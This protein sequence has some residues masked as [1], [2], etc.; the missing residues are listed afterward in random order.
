[1]AAEAVAGT[2]TAGTAATASKAIVVRME[3]KSFIFVPPLR[4]L[5][6]ACREVEVDISASKSLGA[7]N[8]TLGDGIQLLEPGCFP[9]VMLPGVP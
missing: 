4:H 3:W 6:D 1:M 7:R 8:S 9:A 5:F 2:A